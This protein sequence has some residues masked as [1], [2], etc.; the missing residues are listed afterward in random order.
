MAFYYDGYKWLEMEKYK[1]MYIRC[2]V[3]WM[4]SMHMLL[5]EA[6]AYSLAP[7]EGIR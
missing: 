2:M 1:Y 6:K 4:V 5:H 3:T 7:P